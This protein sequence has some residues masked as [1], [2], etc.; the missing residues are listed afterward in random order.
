[1][2]ERTFFRLSLLLPFVVPLVGFGVRVSYNLV[3]GNRWSD[4]DAPEP[5]GSILL[6]VVYSLVFGA[7]PYGVFAAWAWCRIPRQSMA[8]TRAIIALSPLLTMIPHLLLGLLILVAW[9]RSELGNILLHLTPWY[10]LIGCPYV[11]LVFIVYGL[12]RR[13]FRARPDDGAPSMPGS[14]STGSLRSAGG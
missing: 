2:S 11:A 7:G 4:L 3:A 1:M 14:P 6:Y 10:L 13:R 8:T 12:F 9:P 5:F